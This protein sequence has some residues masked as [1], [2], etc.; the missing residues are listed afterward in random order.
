MD[1]NTVKIIPRPPAAGYTPGAINNDLISHSYGR[2]TGVIKL[3]IIDEMAIEDLDTFI[4]TFQEN[5]IRYSVED[6]K[7][8][9]EIYIA[10]I[11]K[12]ISL[13]KTWINDVSFTLKDLEEETIYQAGLDYELDEEFGRIKALPSGNLIEGAAYRINYT[14]WPIKNSN[15]I[16]SEQSN[17]IFDGLKIS[18]Q[19]NELELNQSESGWTKTSSCNS[20]Y[21]ITPYSGNDDYICLL[22]T[23]PSPRDS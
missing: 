3:D 17:P 13:Q 7:Y 8:E 14:Y 12:F 4:V 21:S 19:N 10:K 22:Y 9:T 11:N 1:I 6:T 20:V 15:L 16:N 18:V 5:P 23:S 2:A